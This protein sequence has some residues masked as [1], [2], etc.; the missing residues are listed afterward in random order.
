MHV[1][2]TETMHTLQVHLLLVTLQDFSLCKVRFSWSHTQDSWLTSPACPWAASRNSPYKPRFPT[3]TPRIYGLQ[4]LYF[5]LPTSRLPSHPPRIFHHT[6]PCLTCQFPKPVHFP[7]IWKSWSHS[8][9]CHIQFNFLLHTTQGF[10][11]CKPQFPHTFFNMFGQSHSFHKKDATHPCQQTHLQMYVNTNCH[12]HGHTL[13]TM[14]TT[15]PN[16]CLAENLYFVK[17]EL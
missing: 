6:G 2:H 14:Y 8:R 11:N 1:I 13:C 4:I 12:C 10:C 7:N 3:P 5:P 17:Q 9:N 16:Q 15:H